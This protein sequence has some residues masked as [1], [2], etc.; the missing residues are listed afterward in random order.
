M[1]PH[2]KLP[3][4]LCGKIFSVRTGRH[5]GLSDSRTRSKDLVVP[6]R[7]VRA[8]GMPKSLLERG[9]S[10]LAVMEPH[11]VFSH[12]TAAELWGMPLPKAGEV[13]HVMAIGVRGRMRRPGVKGWERARTET[14]S[15]GACATCLS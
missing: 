12:E 11:Q 1:Q 15:S 8:H 5:H 13:M 14:S 2:G 10:L 3:E 6:F 7:G 9:R 4:P